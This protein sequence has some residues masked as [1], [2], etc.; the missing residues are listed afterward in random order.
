[1]E[2][3]NYKGLVWLVVI[4]IVLVVAL[5]GFI[6]YREFYDSNSNS[7]NNNIID[8]DTTISI[9][10]DVNKDWIYDAEYNGNVLQSSYSI[11]GRS[12]NISD[13]KVPYINI[14][15]DYGTSIN[16]DIKENYNKLIDV[17]NSGIEDGGSY[18]D[19]FKYSYYL[20][21]NILSLVIDFVYAYKGYEAFETKFLVYNINIE[22]GEKVKYEDILEY[23][24]CSSEDLY[25]KGKNALEEFYNDKYTSVINNQKLLKEYREETLNLFEE[26]DFVN[27]YLDGNKNVNFEAEI[28]IPY[29]DGKIYEIITIK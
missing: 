9:K 16:Y 8:G 1:M 3:K 27:I 10:K 20:N 11:E 4:L 23:I 5:M 22:N 13:Y 15:S 29:S 6:L 14:D 28:K 19:E 2:N 18:V 26:N 25:Y 7:L 24:N 21:K 12:Y 17:F